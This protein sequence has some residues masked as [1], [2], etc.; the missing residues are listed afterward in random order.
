MNIRRYI[1]CALVATFP[2][3]VLFSAPQA[4]SD[5][6]AVFSVHPDNHRVFLYQGKP[7]KILTSAEHYGAV[8]N[9]DFDYDVYLREMQRTGQNMT[10][11]FA[12]Y[13]ET[14]DGS[15]GDIRSMVKA[16][17]LAPDRSAAILSVQ[18]V[19]GHGK[20]LN[21]LGKFDLDKWN[22]AYYYSAT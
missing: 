14:A 21:G 17:T 5:A 10:R 7:M 16:N 6:T 9:G 1:I 20:A 15:G 8:V 22:P 13:R 3:H 19:S 18:R 11:V 2:M 4:V 12:F